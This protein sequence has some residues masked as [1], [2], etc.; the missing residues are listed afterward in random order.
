M[1]NLIEIYKRRGEITD[2]Q[3]L[4]IMAFQLEPQG[5]VAYIGKDK[6][7]IVT[8]MGQV[9]RDYHVVDRSDGSWA[10]YPMMFVT[11]R[12]TASGALDVNIDNVIHRVSRLVATAFVPNPMGRRYVCHKSNDVMDNRASNLYWADSPRGTISEED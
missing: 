3:L 7:Y 10:E 1:D 11:Q 5:E 4:D 6:Q 12:Q 2:S 8:S 9:F